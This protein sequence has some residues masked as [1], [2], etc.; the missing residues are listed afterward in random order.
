M[1]WTLTETVCRC[2]GAPAT[3]QPG[4][5][6]GRWSAGTS[7]LAHRSGSLV[8]HRSCQLCLSHQRLFP[9]GGCHFSV[10][11]AKRDLF[12]VR[13]VIFYGFWLNC[14]F[15][16]IILLQELG[17]KAGDIFQSASLRKYHNKLSCQR[18]SCQCAKTCL[19]KGLSK[20]SKKGD[21]NREQQVLDSC[22]ILNVSLFWLYRAFA[23]AS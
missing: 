2:L 8:L 17:A 12:G 16:F 5:K 22:P 9:N 3:G 1:T 19:L 20:M 15:D 21:A 14:C 23:A 7:G 6:G 13:N 10:G 4:P 18:G 11:S